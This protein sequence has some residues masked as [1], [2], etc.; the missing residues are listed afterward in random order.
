MNDATPNWGGH[1]F[2]QAVKKKWPGAQEAFRK[3][4]Q[5]N[6][7]RLLLGSL[8]VVEVDTETAIAS[9]VCQEGYGSSP[10]TRLRYFAL[11]TCLRH[12][13][14]IAEERL[15][16]IHMPRI[17]SGQAGGSWFL[18]QELITN[19]L[20]SEKAPVFVYDLPYAKEKFEDQK[21]LQF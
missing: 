6:P 20:L 7:E 12:L 3:W 2:A 15:A 10:K 8:H 5:E 16:S 19:V 9:M 18:V 14:Q 21:Q 1:G 13:N 17:G 11:E 4:V